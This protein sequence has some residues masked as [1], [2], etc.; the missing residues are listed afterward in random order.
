MTIRTPSI[1]MFIRCHLSGVNS[2]VALKM[3]SFPFFL[4]VKYG[5]VTVKLTFFTSQHHDHVTSGENTVCDDVSCCL[6]E[7]ALCQYYKLLKNCYRLFF[8]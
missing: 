6:L 3:K 4:V 1:V 8:L 5:H 7:L 2:T